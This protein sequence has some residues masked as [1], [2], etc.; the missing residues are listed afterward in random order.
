MALIEMKPKTAIEKKTQTV[1]DTVMLTPESVKKWKSPPFQRPV[2]ENK[3]VVALAEQ[4]KVDGGVL[5]GIIT[6]GVF[7]GETYLLDGQHRT[8]AFLLS[9]LKEGF[10]DVRK[11]YFDSMAEMGD[12]WVLLN[13][14]LVRMGPDDILR[15][16]E[17]SMPILQFI[18]NRCPFVGYD[19]VRRGASSPILGMSA[20]LRCWRSSGTEIPAYTGGA[21]RDIAET[22]TEDDSR[23]L[24]EFLNI[25]FLGFGRESEYSRL[26]SGLNLTICMWLFRQMVKVQWSPKVPRMLSENFKKCLMALS[27]STDYMD[28]LVGRK[29]NDRDR[30][31]A[32]SRI[33]KIFTQ[34]LHMET[35]TRHTM[36]Q[37][38]WAS[39]H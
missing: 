33:R 31:P 7:K 10:T 39:T 26:W 6:L 4:L 19:Q 30:S 18:R 14:Q 13:S 34:R 20:A 29:L 5:P 16:L 35:G 37:P 22:M 3:K 23:D 15:G 11:H 28:W 24:V 32:Y 36:P 8:R 1:A 38:P 21:A 27:A 12:E 2:K 25:A 9:G 17:G